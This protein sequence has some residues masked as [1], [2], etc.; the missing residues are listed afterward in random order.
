MG[1]GFS[2]TFRRSS[3]PFKRRRMGGMRRFSFRRTLRRVSKQLSTF[4]SAS[5]QWASPST[6]VGGSGGTMTCVHN[7][8]ASS[9]SNGYVHLSGIAGGTGPSVRLGNRAQLLRLTVK[10]ITYT[11][12]QA[13]G[14]IINQGRVI[15]YMVRANGGDGLGVGNNDIVNAI[16]NWTTGTASGVFGTWNPQKVPTSIRIIKDININPWNTPNPGTG[17]GN[18]NGA[19]VRWDFSVNLRKYMGKDKWSTWT[20]SSNAASDSDANQ[21][22]AA[23]IQTTPTPADAGALTSVFGFK[24][25]FLP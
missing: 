24:L 4:R 23:F 10:G 25:T 14:G 17:A 9:T 15:F 7:N 22:F 21:V 5:L 8:A 3:R 12:V 20:G 6:I 1:F 18:H 16:M 13:N 2:R 11:G 19:V